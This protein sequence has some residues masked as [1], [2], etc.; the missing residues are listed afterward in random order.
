MLVPLASRIRG[1]SPEVWRTATWAAP[2][3]VQGVFA[4]A[5][6]IGWLL[7]RFPIN[8]DARICLVVVV[9]T[10]IATDASLVLAARL[11][12]AQSPRRHGLGFA[13]GGAAVAV[14]AVGLSFVLAFLTVLRP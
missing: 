9:T 13:L 12:C 7:A 14:A 6:G 1:S 2:L 11:L 3:V 4:A 5:L 10:T 8:T